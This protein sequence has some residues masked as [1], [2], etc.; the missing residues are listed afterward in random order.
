MEVS[1]EILR[2]AGHPAVILVGHPNYYPRFGFLPAE[3]WGLSVAFEV[4]P[5]VFQ[6]IEL[7][8]GALAG[9][10]GTIRFRP[11]FVV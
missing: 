10:A 2:R 8:P 3:E 7:Q 1:L 9:V 11:E 6:A 4:P 5:G